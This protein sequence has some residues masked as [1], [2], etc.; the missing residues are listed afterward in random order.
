MADLIRLLAIGLALFIALQAWLIVRRLRRPPRRTYASAVSRGNPGDPSEL[1][2]SAYGSDS[3]ARLEFAPFEFSAGPRGLSLPAWDI[4]G[5][6]ADDPAAPLIIITPGWGDSK[7]GALPRLAPFWAGASRIIAWDPAGL[8]DAPGLC[9]LGTERDTRALFEL[10]RLV[11]DADPAR[12]ILL[13]GWSMGAGMS[14]VA[15]GELRALGLPVRAVIAEAPYR[16]A[17]TPVVN[18][19]TLTRMPHRLSGPIALAYLGLRLRASLSWA[20]FDRASFAR[21]LECPLL[22]I[23]GTLDAFCPHDDGRAIATAA[24]RSLF[25]SIEGAGHNDLWTDERFRPQCERAVADFLAAVRE[26]ATTQA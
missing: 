22:V 18:Y 3:A 15:A 12:P 14:I 2:L 1:D 16:L 8:G 13:M 23:H 20:S 25:I 9:G 17:P 10:A 11:H 4:K 19:L 26:P 24:R 7:V 5:A 21:K 6:R